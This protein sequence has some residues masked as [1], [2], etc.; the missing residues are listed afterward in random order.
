M[1]SFNWFMMLGGLAFFFFGLFTARSAL[2]LLAGDRLR[3]VI[4]K[5]TKNRFF[6][7]GLGAVVTCIL[8]SSTAATVMLVSFA[9]TGILTLTQAFGVIL[10]ADIGTTFVVVLLS[11]KKIAE[12]SLLMVALG[13][14]AE[15]VSKTKNIRYLGRIVFSFG[16]VFYGMHLMT[17]SAFPLTQSP[18]AFAIFSFL[19]NHPFV[20]LMVAAVFTAAVHNSAAT[21]GLAIALA[22]SGALSLTAAVPMVLG[23]NIGTTATALM[24]AFSS[25]TNGKRVAVAHIFVKVTGAVAAFFFIPEIVYGIEHCRGLLMAFLPMLEPGVA[26]LIAFFHL[27]FNVALAL[28]FLPFISLGVWLITRMVP[29]PKGQKAFGPNYL[30]PTALETPALAFANAKRETLRIANLTYDLFD[31]CLDLF[32]P[33]EEVIR[34]IEIVETHDDKIDL[35]EKEVRFYLSRLSQEQ[36]TEK[37]A[38]QEMALLSIADDCE[39]IGDTISKEF[40]RLARKKAEKHRRFS[41]P[42]WKDLN[43]LHELLRTNFTLTIAALTSPD[44][45]VIQR[46]KRHCD[47]FQEEEQN[48]RQIGRAARRGR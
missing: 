20:S 18:E 19:E 17:Q 21:I 37:Q 10:G 22:L 48:L 2:Q 6:A 41:D 1:Q 9:S 13:Y 27:T 38:A 4:A 11:V 33:T 3:M 14:L 23:A 35:L 40:V 31:E 7:V 39:G 25:G 28:L 26:G 32:H 34:T 43:H 45:E 44:E 42:G 24:A 46:A 16:M 12:Y 36:L 29:E 30:D 5:M 47:Q 15:G 8:Q